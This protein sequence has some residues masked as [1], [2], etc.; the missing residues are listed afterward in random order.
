MPES[1][2]RP[3][4]L[5]ST[6]W[7]AEHLGDPSIVIAEVNTDMESGYLQGHV[8]GAVGWNLHVD[9][10]DQV[11]RDIPSVSQIER[12]LGSAGID[13]DTTVVLY[14]DGNN[15]SAT[16]GFWVLKYYRHRDVRLMDGGRKK[17]T[18]E[19]RPLST[20][21]P[22]PHAQ[23]VQSGRTGPEREGDQGVHSRPPAPT[24]L[25]AAGHPNLRGVRGRTDLGARHSSV[26]YLPQGTHPRRHFRPM[27]RR[28]HRGRH[29]QARR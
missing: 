10:E 12:L 8:P 18:E 25:Q 11:R 1:Y 20:E 3:D 29:L 23:G 21:R 14:G 27:G 26:R 7:V 22:V 16:W 17:W 6:D 15:R 2:A 5:V 9:L 28:C 13:N 4:V 24:F 19:G